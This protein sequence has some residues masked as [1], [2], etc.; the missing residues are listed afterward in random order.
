MGYRQSIYDIYTNGS[1]SP[2]ITYAGT[3]LTG[4]SGTTYYWRIRFW[5]TD[6]NVSNWSDT[7]TFKDFIQTEE[8]IRMEKL[9]LEGIKIN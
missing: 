8:Y 6:G 9:K 1:R 4:S 7:A 2:E 3:A 5:D